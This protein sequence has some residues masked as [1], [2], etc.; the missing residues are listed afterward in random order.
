[1]NPELPKGN[2]MIR[3]SILGATAFAILATCVAAAP[4]SAKSGYSARMAKKW[5]H[6]HLEAYKA[7]HSGFIAYDD[8]CRTSRVKVWDAYSGRTVWTTQTFC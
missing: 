5:E 7:G 4:A 8:E 2:P 1:M 3:K 6:L